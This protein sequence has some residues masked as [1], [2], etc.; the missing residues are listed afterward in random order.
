MDRTQRT[1]TFAGLALVA[2]SLVGAVVVSQGSGDV[3][4][5]NAPTVTNRNHGG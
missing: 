4:L 5:G 2:A 3:M 1:A